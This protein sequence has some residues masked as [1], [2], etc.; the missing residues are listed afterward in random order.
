MSKMTFEIKCEME[1]EFVPCFIAML[2]QMQY[3]GNLGHS[4]YVGL[5]SDGDG[6]F[7]PKF[8]Y[9]LEKDPDSKYGF[10]KNISKPVY[11]TFFDTRINY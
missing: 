9:I 10:I 4:C 11:G 3:C 6:L 1:E 7:R 8:E 5:Y 2:D